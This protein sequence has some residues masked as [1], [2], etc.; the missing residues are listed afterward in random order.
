MSDDLIKRSDAIDAI[1]REARLAGGSVAIEYADMF[2]DALRSVPSAD[3]PR[4]EWMDS[5][6]NFV[7]LDENGCTTVS[8]W[9]S[10]CGEWLTGSDEYLTS[11]QFCPNCGA[12]MRRR[13]GAKIVANGNCAL[14]GK[15][16][17]DGRLFVCK[18]CEER[19]S[20]ELSCGG[21]EIKGA[22]DEVL[23]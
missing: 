16:L 1:H 8:A 21:A 9:C 6:G 11:G 13:L 14:C 12:R 20:K 2:Q 4:A 17:Q 7:P 3:R 10:N 5:D 18:E 19:I 22:D 15:P 23:R